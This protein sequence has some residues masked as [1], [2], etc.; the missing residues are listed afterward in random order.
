MLPEKLQNN[1]V[2]ETNSMNDKGNRVGVTQSQGAL[3]VDADKSID[4]LR[5]QS[6]AEAGD[7]KIAEV[8]HPA[9]KG[10][11]NCCKD[12]VLREKLCKKLQSSLSVTKIKLPLYH[13]KK[14]EYAD[15]CHLGCSLLILFFLLM[16]AI[17]QLTTFGRI[18]QYFPVIK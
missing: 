1:M 16:Y 4:P 17:L 14:L 11:M 2:H 8:E 15:K 13:D 3:D 9:K 5:K 18:E 7:A 10:K 6:G 12:K